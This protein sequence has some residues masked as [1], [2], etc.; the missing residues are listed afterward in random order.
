MCQGRHALKAELE[1][2]VQLIRVFRDEEKLGDPYLWCGTLCRVERGVAEMMGVMQ[3]PT[4]EA[5]HAIRQAVL[6]GG[7]KQL[8]TRYGNGR[9]REVLE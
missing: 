7:Y 1:P 6:A 5:W 4:P 8:I 9:I 2:L 3:A